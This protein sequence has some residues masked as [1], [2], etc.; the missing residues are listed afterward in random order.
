M[1]KGKTLNTLVNMKKS[2][3]AHQ[4]PSTISECVRRLYRNFSVAAGQDSKEYQGLQ[5]EILNDVQPRDIP[6][7]LWVKDIVDQVWEAQQL[8][9]IRARLLDPQPE[10]GS[11]SRP[12]VPDKLLAILMNPP[13]RRFSANEQ[14]EYDAKIQQDAVALR[15]EMWAEEQ[16]MQRRSKSP[17]DPTASWLTE[18]F[19][20][21]A[22][23]ER[24]SRMIALADARRDAMLDR[25]E[26]RRS[27]LGSRLRQVS[28]N[29]IEAEFTMAEDQRRSRR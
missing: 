11:P 7:G 2:R 23:L 27:E 22:E 1:A 8:R 28:D 26:K 9:R 14:K 25:I 24:L 10:V 19:K 5:T 18:Y 13:M 16:K 15:D 3:K 4:L 12:H 21:S 6:E 20:H 17:D 29:I